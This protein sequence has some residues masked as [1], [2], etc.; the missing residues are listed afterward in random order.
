[1]TKIR[2]FVKFIGAEILIVLLFVISLNN[3]LDDPVKTIKPI[4]GDGI[5]YYEY[6]PSIFIHHDINRHQLSENELTDFEK[7]VK[8]FGVYVDYFGHKVDKYPCGT[9]LLQSPFFLFVSGT[10]NLQGNAND[11]YQT[12]FQHAVFYAA[13]FYL[14]LA[15]IFLKKILKRYDIERTTIILTQF[16]MVFATSVTQYASSNAAFSHVYSLFAITAFLYFGKQY[17][18]RVN[19]KSFV[20]ACFFWG[21]V[22]ILRQVNVIILFFVPFLAGSIEK[23]KEGVFAVFRRPAMLLG[24]FAVF[25]GMVFIQSYLWY[26]QTGSFFVYSYQG[27]GFNFL[28]PQ[29]VN[30][31]FS[32]RKGLFVYTPVLLFGMIGAIW[33]GVRKKYFVSFSWLLFFFFLT[34]IL[35]SWWSWYYGSSYGLRAYID[36]YALFF[37]P[38]ALVFDSLNRWGKLGMLILV[39]LTVPLNLIQT[40]QYQKYILNST[41]MDKEKYWEVFLKT[42]ESYRGILYKKRFDLKKLTEVYEK[43]IDQVDM[44]VNAEKPIWSIKVSEIG[45]FKNVNIIQVS[46]DDNFEPDNDSRLVLTIDSPEKHNYYYHRPYLIHF[47]EQSLGGNQTGFY[48]YELP[49]FQDPDQLILTFKVMGGTKGAHLKNLKIEFFQKE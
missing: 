19:L 40:Y 14:F 30:I 8:P 10:H 31:L 35:S 17:F 28:D 2:S 1:M 37:I 3:Y 9:A 11:G 42:S 48:N 22:V 5:G 44:P 21:L 41:N 7:R 23:L 26:L 4:S 12:P 13:L 34:Y 15:L 18:E 20:W 47:A 29:F 36:F 24:G 32:Y 46:F 38:F 49:A 43:Q 6:L 33:L 25:S 45:D 39:L 27:E 16:L